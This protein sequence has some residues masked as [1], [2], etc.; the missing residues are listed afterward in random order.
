LVV[1]SK[2]IVDNKTTKELTNIGQQ[3]L[4]SYLRFSDVRLGLLMDF[5]VLPLIDEVSRVVNGL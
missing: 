1:E 5:N 2:V 3:A 4:L